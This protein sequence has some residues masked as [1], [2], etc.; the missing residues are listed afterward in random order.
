MNDGGIGVFGIGSTNFRYAALSARGTF[1]TDPAVEP[2]RPFDLETQLQAA[3]DSLDEQITESLRGVAVATAGLVDVENGVVHDMDTPGGETVDRIDV[4][5]AVQEAM[6]VPVVV[7][8]DCNAAALGEWTFGAR[9]EHTTVVHVTFGTGIGGGI[10]EDGDLLRGEHAQ[11][12][13]FGLL[14][15][16][17]HVDVESTGVPGAWEACCSG[18]GIPQF[19]ASLLDT[20][21]LSDVADTELAT[22][23]A[24]GGVD[25]EEI[26]AA[27]EDGDAFARACLD[28]VARIN[29]AGIAA[30]CHT[31]NPGL[32]TLGGGVALNNPQWIRAGIDDH[33]DEFLFVDR[34]EIRLT[35]LGDDIGLYGAVAAFLERESAVPTPQYKEP[36]E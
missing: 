29:A 28:R 22:R 30:I 35:E 19:A 14:P 32:I 5:D 4:R 8:N 27:C 23:I 17:P 9:E 16:A 20:G 25:A 18:R 1:L 13:E 31:V 11:S 7:V 26:F 15:L 36:A 12:A 2:T 6:D 34:P 21:T 10:V 3:V 33:L 24:E